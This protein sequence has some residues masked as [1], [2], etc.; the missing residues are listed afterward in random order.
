[1]NDV[2]NEQSN[3]SIK[4]VLITGSNGMIGSALMNYLPTQ[5]FEVFGALR[6]TTLVSDEAELKDKNHLK[7]IVVGE[8]N[9]RTDWSTALK[10]VDVV[11]HTAAC[12]HQMQGS[13]DYD[14]VNH[15]GTE[16]L[17]KQAAQAGVKRFIFLSSIKAIG[18]QGHFKSITICQPQDDYG[19]SKLDAEQKLTEISKQTGMELVILRLPLIY[20]PGVKANFR[21]LIQIVQLCSLKRIP[22]PFKGVKNVRSMM[23]LRNLVDCITCC[24]NH[25]NASGM[26]Y[27]PSDGVPISTPELMK[28]IAKALA[29]SNQAKPI[30]L[31][32]VPTS[33]LKLS[34]V[35]IGK[36]ALADR[37]LGNLTVDS[38]LIQEDLSWQAPYT[39]DEELRYT[40]D[41]FIKK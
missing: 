12:V 32:F 39:V 13:K 23:G 34:F 19:Q 4:R 10:N 35:L 6:T 8:I 41:A 5:G 16:Q 11:L 29:A 36:K 24:I 22:I 14:I 9:Q 28:K 1:M 25:S 2:G 27:L 18:E 30:H 40:I 26:M 38:R 20:G 7:H 15:L 31:F 37:L 17:A 21:K 33:L 3:Q